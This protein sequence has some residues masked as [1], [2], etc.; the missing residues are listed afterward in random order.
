V[1]QLETLARG[2]SEEE[3]C[4]RGYLQI[5]RLQLSVTK[6]AASL[7]TKLR[8]TPRSTVDRYA[9]K[10]VRSGPKPSEDRVAGYR[11]DES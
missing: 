7:A 4:S 11:M 6:T 8:L 1:A 2:L 5:L 9:R 10:I 3:P